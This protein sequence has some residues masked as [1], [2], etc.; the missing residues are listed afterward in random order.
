MLGG[1]F[2]RSHNKP[3]IDESRYIRT[4]DQDVLVTVKATPEIWNDMGSGARG[5]RME[6][7]GV[8]RLLETQRLSLHAYG[9][10][11]SCSRI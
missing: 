5:R 1:I 6:L 3:T 9:C 4:I 11:Y 10:I 7:F 2:V 8:F